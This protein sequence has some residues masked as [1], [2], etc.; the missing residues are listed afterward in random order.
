MT[1]TKLLGGNHF[2]WNISSWISSNS[3][4]LVNSNDSKCFKYVYVC[5]YIYMYIDIYIYIYTPDSQMTNLSHSLYKYWD[6]SCHRQHIHLFLILGATSNFLV[7]PGSCL[8]HDFF[9]IWR[10]ERSQKTMVTLPHPAVNKKTNKGKYPP[11]TT[12][13]PLISLVH[14]HFSR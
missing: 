8:N 10:A 6:S 5:I 9:T 3:V 14:P 2:F 13:R 4:L 7:P 1:W 11:L 12:T